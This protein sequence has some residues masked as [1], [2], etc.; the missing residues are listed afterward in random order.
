MT[1]EE[2]QILFEATDEAWRLGHQDLQERTKTRSAQSALQ[3]VQNASLRCFMTCATS[4][5]FEQRIHWNTRRSSV[6]INIKNFP[7]TLDN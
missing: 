3:D 1:K 7:K 6:T 2:K 4:W 5:V